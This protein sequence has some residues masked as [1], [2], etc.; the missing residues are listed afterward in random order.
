MLDIVKCK[1]KCQATLLNNGL[2]IVEVVH[3]LLNLYYWRWSWPQYV[4]DLT[5]KYVV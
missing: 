5:Q 3:F 1:E 4:K 2:C